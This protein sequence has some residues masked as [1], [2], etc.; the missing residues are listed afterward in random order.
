M[1]RAATRMLSDRPGRCER[2]TRMLP[3]DRPGCC[4]PTDP[5]P[6]NCPI[7]LQVFSYT[8]APLFSCA[9]AELLLCS[10]RT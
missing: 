5:V 10:C 4:R 6:K 2:A 8:P 1:L 9:P 7:L 3:T